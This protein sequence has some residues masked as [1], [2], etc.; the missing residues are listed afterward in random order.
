MG[1]VAFW[2]HTLG[3][4]V[5]GVGGHVQHIIA[6]PMTLMCSQCGCRYVHGASFDTVNNAHCNPKPGGP[7]RHACKDLQQM[8]IRAQCAGS[9]ELCQRRK[10]PLIS[11]WM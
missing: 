10:L 9:V 7:I 11:S 4:W 3:V 2:A 6:T 8:H 5:E 1:G